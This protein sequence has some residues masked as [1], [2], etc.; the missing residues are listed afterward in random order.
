[1][2]RWRAASPS[3]RFFPPARSVPSQPSTCEQSQNESAPDSIESRGARLNSPPP[4]PVHN[5]LNRL[6]LEGGMARMGHG[7]NVYVTPG[8]RDFGHYD[9]VTI[10]GILTRTGHCAVIARMALWRA[11][12]AELTGNP[13][14][15]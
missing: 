13:G 14:G 4:K 3:Q 15:V 10:V 9:L 12:V 5:H 1:M 8:W 11:S 7:K 6:G 2:Q